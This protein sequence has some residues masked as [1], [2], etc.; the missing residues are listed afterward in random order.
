MTNSDQSSGRSG[1]AK[2]RRKGLGARRGGSRRAPLPPWS[3]A[4][5]L[6]RRGV[7]GGSEV[8]AEPGYVRPVQCQKGPG[9]GGAASMTAGQVGHVGGHRA[10]LST[11]SPQGSECLAAGGCP[12]HHLATPGVPGGYLA[13]V[14]P[15]NRVWFWG[16][17]LG[18]L[19]P[20]CRVPGLWKCG[21]GASPL[22]TVF[23]V[24]R[25]KGGAKVGD[26]FWA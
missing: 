16:Y 22:T 24:A 3:G 26:G 15:C 6:A 13:I 18:N 14:P 25:G 11:P 8:P 7:L 10:G 21:G 19:P 12:S 20:C 1:G 9:Y 5:G 4:R 17:P 23:R 2:G